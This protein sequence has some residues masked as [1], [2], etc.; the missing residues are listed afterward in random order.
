MRP[1]RPALAVHTSASVEDAAVHHRLA[2]LEEEVAQLRADN[3][4]LNEA[5]LQLGTE[6]EMRQSPLGLA[7]QRGAVAT[8]K[9]TERFHSPPPPDC[10]RSTENFTDL[11]SEEPPES[12]RALRRRETRK[13]LKDFKDA[14]R[15]AVARTRSLQSADYG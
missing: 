3:A 9:R 10:L 11:V 12:I 8:E 7:R 4:R 6:N 15:T 13:F 2:Q 5:L 1:S 14:C